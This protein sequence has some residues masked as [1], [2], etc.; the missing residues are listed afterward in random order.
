MNPL[1]S[2]FE[3]VNTVISR[4]FPDK[5]KAQEIQLE[6]AKMQLSGELSQLEKESAE[7]I[8]QM[9]INKEEAKS[10][11][12]FISGW[13][14][15]IGWA[16]GVAYVFAYI[17]APYIINPILVAYGHT[18]LPQVDFSDMIAVLLGM[19]GLGGMRTYEK[20]KGIK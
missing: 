8:A 17:V 13:R 11:N 20:R 14:P 16:C 2:I 9:E 7:R 6:L 19:L 3:L 12:V 5:S 10:E 18:A 1:T 15:F 4:V